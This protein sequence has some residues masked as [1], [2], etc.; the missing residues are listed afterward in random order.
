MSL[1][2]KSVLRKML[3]SVFILMLLAN[4]TTLL[5]NII[6]ASPALTLKWS[7]NL[8]QNSQ[9]WIG[10]LAADI[11]NDGK[12]EIVVTGGSGQSTSDGFVTALDG[13]TGNIVWQVQPGG[14]TTH[15]PFD[16]VDL[17]NDGELEI[18]ISTLS[19]G[20][21]AL[22]A[23]N[24]STYWRNTAAKSDTPPDGHTNAIFDIDDDGYMEIYVSGGRGPFQGYDYI[25][26]LSHDGR[27]LR[28]TTCWHPCYGGLT[29]ADPAFNGTFILYQG[30]RS[31]NYNPPNDPYKYGGWGVRALDART[32]APLWN[33]SEILCSS[34]APMLA[35]VDK[36]GILDVIVAHQSRGLAVYNAFTGEVLTTGGKYR[37]SL[38]LG[39]RSH[40]QPTI[41]DIDYDGNLEFITARDSSI[42]VFDLYDWKLDAILP[43]TVM[44]PPKVGDVTG[45]GKMDIIAVNSTGIYIYT[46][47][48]ATKNYEMVEY[49]T[50]GGNAFTLVADVDNDG[51]NELIVTTGG[52]TVRCYD[53]PARTP[54]P[55]PRTNIQFYSEY[56]LG[57]A[58]Y[59]SP[60]GPKAPQITEPSPTDGATNVPI[61]LS[62]LT[63][64][65]TDYQ[66]DP[67]NYTVTTY[68]DI[69]S[70][71]GKNVRNG[72]ITV[73]ASGLAYSTTYTWTVTA[74]DGTH[75]TT[76]TFTFTTSDL[77]PW[78]NTD[79]QYRKTIIIDHTKVSGDQ[80]NFPVLIDLTDPSLTSK[81]EPDGDDFLFTDQ[82]NNKLDHQIEY[83]DSAS[84]HLIAWVRI[85]YLSSTTDTK[86]YLYYGNPSCE[87]QQNPSAVWDASYKLV[88]HLNEKSGTHKDSTV[89]G[90][91]GTPFNGVQQ[92]VAAK[93]DG[94]DTFDGTND[95]IEIAHSDTLAGFTEALTVSFWVR[96]EDTSRRQAILN[97][98]NT[99]TNQRGWFIEYNPVDRP[100][101]PFGF[102]ASPDGT[103]YREW[104][105]SF[106]PA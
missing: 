14:I 93:I 104:Y 53:T 18:V 62:Q 102:Y 17:N 61:T 9:M 40:S 76:K 78:Y 92:G 86:L 101:R 43:T 91:N 97:K 23:K 75:T 21:L 13:A 8:G 71:S 81:T 44:E 55:P 72:K 16:I 42:Y 19:V 84:G 106:V 3:C 69:G 6:S 88:L 33:D 31:I 29:I 30:D 27:I 39:L 58:E 57:A 54:N 20:T 59:V 67:I 77:P 80:T 38:D 79:W 32:L 103:N 34:Q 70:A 25:T 37:K 46:Y 56:H 95:Y 36:D 51:Y 5:V 66:H 45:D 35:D 15:S 49:V 73:P 98:Y 4:I 1:I 24:G 60:P 94:G 47:N 87:S 82:D 52:G 105:A 10:A 90:N 12:I 11:N 50:P 41:Y 7:R 100:T 64:K 2:K 74:T 68:P 89:Y 63:F 65:L 48:Q 99:G 28:Q 83:Y 85:P 26:M 22:H 96:L